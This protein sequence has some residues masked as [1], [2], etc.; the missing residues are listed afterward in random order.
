MTDQTSS[1]VIRLRADGAQQA[2]AAFEAFGK[3]AEAAVRQP[4]KA[5]AFTSQQ[6]GQLNMQMTDIVVGL[7]T[8]Q[9]PLYVL[10]Q[11]GGQ[12]KDMFGGVGGAAR[13][14]AAGIGSMV[15]PVTLAAAAVAGIGGALYTGA[16][17]SVAFRSALLASGNAAGITEGQFNDLT[18][19]IAEGAGTTLSSSREIAQG[20]VA[21]GQIG[22]EAFDK[23]AMGA[24]LLQ[25]A[26]GQTADEVVKDMVTMS[27][28]VESWARKH[29]E[30]WHFATSAQLEH[31]RALEQAG[32]KQ[33]AM[34]ETLDLLNPHL[35][36]QGE[37]LGWLERMWRGVTG[38]VDRYKDSLLALGR[39]TTVDDQ[40]KVA[41]QEL[42]L[43]QQGTFRNAGFGDQ[44]GAAVAGNWKSKDQ[45]LADQRQRVADLEL[46]QRD[47]R[48]RAANRAQAIVED[49]A[50]T[51]RREKL[52]QVTEDLTGANSAY[53]KTLETIQKSLKA[54]DI[55]QEQ[56][57]ELLTQAATKFGSGVSAAKKEKA[58]KLDYY[59]T[60]DF[61]GPMLPSPTGPNID[62]DVLRARERAPADLARLQAE[63]LDQTQSLNISLIADDR[64]RGEAQ[65]E[66]ERQTLQAR[67]DLMA[68]AGVDISA[69][70][71][72]LNAYVLASQRRLTEELKPEWQRMLEAWGDTTR[73]M[74]DAYNTTM[75]RMVNEGESAFVQLMTTGK[76]NVR[77]LANAFLEEQ[78]RNTYRTLVAPQVSKA[79][80]WLMGQMGMGPQSGPSFSSSDWEQQLRAMSD[81]TAR[82]TGQLTEQSALYRML[83]ERLGAFGGGLVS[84]GEKLLQFIVSLGSGS[85]GS[86]LSAIFSK[87][88]SLGSGTGAG[89]GADGGSFSSSSWE[90]DLA[91]MNIR[92][93]ADGGIS[94]GPTLAMVSEGRYRNEAH[95]PL[96]NGRSVPV[97]LNGGA[98]GGP[99]IHQHITYNFAPG[100][101]QADLRVLT[102]RNNRQLRA[103]TLAEATRP[104]RA[105]WKAARS[106]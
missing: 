40:L 85:S 5:A 36:A 54:G 64:A 67:L 65:I 34:A 86:G 100:V 8:G 102:E 96:P 59:N 23:V 76:L 19:Q 37:N 72:S 83:N 78:A 99:V 11:Q 104:G 2:G 73:Q 4:G 69:A 97:E 30:Q 25:R 51:D 21:S 49:K 15:N 105:L 53:A 58:P 24:A 32:Q 16:E 81:A 45:L 63:L 12:L 75:T 84:A 88:F 46:A 89:T 9:S 91:A 61:M 27:Q 56:A 77:G 80:G 43:M 62:A 6:M 13:A 52:R 10:L 14:L 90:A 50:L 26:T 20:L 17:Q 82:Q 74:A 87:L 92:K 38:E 29:N 22:R 94:T 41:R 42:Q 60:S 1:Y 18:R 33:Q 44:I 71:D 47:Q 7:S 79:T 106:A 101:T 39:D 98:A 95:I 70:Q 57:N 55:T 68:A 3:K 66:Q 31:I 35:R 28:G 48:I 103:E 93:F